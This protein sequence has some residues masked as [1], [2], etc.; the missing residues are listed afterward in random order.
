MCIQIILTV[1]TF[2]LGNF[3]NK[4]NRLEQLFLS[5]LNNLI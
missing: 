4:Q 5:I 2:N 1:I 3:I